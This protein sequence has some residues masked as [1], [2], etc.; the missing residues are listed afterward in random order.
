MV[1][2]RNRAVLL[3]LLIVGVIFLTLYFGGSGTEVV[4]FLQ[5][6]VLNITS[7]L[8][9]LV[10]RIISP[11]GDGW[12]YV[13]SF[14]NMRDENDRLRADNA[15]L[16]KRVKRLSI[17]KDE[18]VR[19]RRLIGLKESTSFTYIPARVIGRSSSSWQSILIIDKGDKNGLEKNMPVVIDDGV[20]GKI[21]KVGRNTSEVL[22]LI[23]EKSGVG[24]EIERTGQ[25][26]IVEGRTGGGLNLNYIPKESDVKKGDKLWTSG[27]GLVY[28][29]HFKVGEVIEVSEDQYDMEMKIKVEPA[30]DFKSLIE[31]LVITEPTEKDLP[32]KTVSSK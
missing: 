14:S 7:P 23:D 18:N 24:V 17:E 31:L 26:G 12:T 11:I 6:A 9:H 21:L 15:D 19:L 5:R 29:R 30:V 27:I 20:I 22:M 13:V 3:V 16:N 2:S 28:P 8:Y 10:D 25:R 1:G 4:A 32:G